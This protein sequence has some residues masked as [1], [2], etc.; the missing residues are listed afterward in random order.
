MEGSSKVTKAGLFIQKYYKDKT[1]II[2]LEPVKARGSLI[3]LIPDNLS[4]STSIMN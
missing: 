4:G 1:R 3:Y 2:I